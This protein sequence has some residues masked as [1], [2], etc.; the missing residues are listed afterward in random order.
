MDGTGT[1]SDGTG[2]AWAWHG[3][4]IG[5]ARGRHGDGM[6]MVSEV[7]LYDWKFMNDG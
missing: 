4:G 7:N 1:A 5:M 2:M 6:G 3:D